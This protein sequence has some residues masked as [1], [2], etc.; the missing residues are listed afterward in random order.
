MKAKENDTSKVKGGKKRIKNGRMI[1]V[2]YLTLFTLKR[3]RLL[4]DYG[5]DG[6][7]LQMPNS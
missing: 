7:I 1:A 4:S 6:L 3:I 2:F 5:L